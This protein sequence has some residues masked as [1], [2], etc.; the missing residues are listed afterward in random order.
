MEIFLCHDD[1]LVATPKSLL[2][3]KATIEKKFK[4][5]DRQF[6]LQ[7][8]KAWT[9]FKKDPMSFY[10]RWHT[11]TQKENQQIIYQTLSSL[12]LTIHW[13]MITLPNLIGLQDK[14]HGSPES[15]PHMQFC[16]Y[17]PTKSKNL[18]LWSKAVTLY[19]SRSITA[20]LH[21]YAI[22]LGFWNGS[23]SGGFY[24]YFQNLLRNSHKL[25]TYFYYQ[26][27]LITAICLLVQQ[28]R[29][30]ETI[31]DGRSRAPCSR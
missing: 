31:S 26:T 15:Q 11:C 2:P 17:A 4:C 9:L 20:C 19:M 28:L 5:R 1:I 29:Y 30:E 13:K 8:S 14:L 24:A 18:L 22:F 27:A 23:H 21:N 6:F 12:S 7:H 10:P 3:S 16:N 25:D